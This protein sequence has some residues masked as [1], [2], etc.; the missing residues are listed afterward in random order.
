M[1]KMKVLGRGLSALIPGKDQAAAQPASR[2]AGATELELAATQLGAPHAQTLMVGDSINDVKAARELWE[3]NELCRA[4][5]ERKYRPVSS[6]VSRS[7]C[8]WARSK[9]SRSAAC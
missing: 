1:I 7:T 9:P 5:A 4:R 3:A 2:G 6:P 8:A